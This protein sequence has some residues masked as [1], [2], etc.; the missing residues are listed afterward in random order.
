MSKLLLLA[1]AAFVFC[2]GSVILMRLIEFGFAVADKSLEN[3]GKLVKLP[4]QVTFKL[5]AYSIRWV[6]KQLNTKRPDEYTVTPLYKVTPLHLQH[7]RN[8]LLSSDNKQ[9]PVVIE[10]TQPKRL[11]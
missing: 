10:Y 3:S 6:F 4:F 1:I 9:D 8:S 11:K 2:F 5:I 7:M